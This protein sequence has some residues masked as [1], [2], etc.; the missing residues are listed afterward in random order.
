MCVKS[1][2]RGTHLTLYNPT[3]L[4]QNA[5]RVCF[6]EGFTA[7]CFGFFIDNHFCSLDV[8]FIVIAGIFKDT[9]LLPKEEVGDWL[10]EGES[11]C[12]Q[13]ETAAHIKKKRKKKRKGTYT[14]KYILTDTLVR[15]GWEIYIS[16]LF[17]PYEGNHRFMCFLSVCACIPQT[18]LLRPLITD[19]YCI[20][21]LSGN[22]PVR[23][24][25]ADTSVRKASANKTPAVT[26]IL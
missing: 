24:E 1:C 20:T 18:N 8:P 15:T 21:Q 17:V 23:G 7:P 12:D 16:L 26:S 22:Q 19:V 10:W 5:N 25:P 9:S 14:P 3:F 2:L 6:C 11:F 13:C 4:H